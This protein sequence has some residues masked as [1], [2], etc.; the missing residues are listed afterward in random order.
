MHRKIIVLGCLIISFS[1]AFAQETK[2]ERKDLTDKIFALYQKDDLEQAIELGEKLVKLEKSSK[3]S[4]SYVNAVLN[5]ARLKREYYVSLQNKMMGRQLNALERREIA[6]KAGKN[7][8]DSEILFREALE[9]NEKSG[10]E[11]TAQ[12]ADIKRDLAWMV[13]NHTY[14]GQ[15]TVE[16]SRGRIDEAEKLLL[17]SIALS[18]QTRGKDADET[19]FAVLD[20]GDLYYKYVNFEKAQ[21]FYERFIKAYE[22]K[23]R[24]N[25]PDLVRALR[26]YANILFTTLQDL[27]SDAVVKRIESIT[28]KKEPMP[29]GEINLHLRSKDSVA[30]SAPIIM[31]MN[32]KAEN[33]RNR[34]KAEGKTLNTGNITS[35]PRNSVVPVEIE[36]DETGKVTKAAAKTDNDK[37]RAE[38]ESVVSKWS[39]RPFSY[40]GTA[41]KMRGILL[42]RKAN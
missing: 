20:A 42:Y 30:Y 18:E 12:T 14:S 33:F 27:E 4:A 31:E 9:L 35:M 17:D 2:N 21:S 11:K 37:L 13:S 8:D 3:D 40:N 34:L 1:S 24:P 39:V 7:A 15:K 29:K 22:Q 36:I 6:E 41:R 28:N 23:H 10:K 32:E 5:L 26:P 25:H 19:L 16:K 38:A